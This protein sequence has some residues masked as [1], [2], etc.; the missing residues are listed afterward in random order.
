MD[1]HQITPKNAILNTFSTVLVLYIATLSFQISV[2]YAICASS[3]WFTFF[4]LSHYQILDS[5]YEILDHNTETISHCTSSKVCCCKKCQND[6]LI[7]LTYRFI[8]DAPRKQIPSI[9]AGDL[10]ILDHISEFSDAVIPFDRTQR[11][12]FSVEHAYSFSDLFREVSGTYFKQTKDPSDFWLIVYGDGIP[13]LSR[14]QLTEAWL[15]QYR[16]KRLQRLL[17]SNVDF[18]KLSHQLWKPNGIMCKRAWR[19]IDSLVN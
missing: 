11:A 5:D 13:V 15:H 1:T 10:F 6:I 8:K 4:T 16:I 12:V 2:S 14:D 7:D 9:S 19:M 3:Y 18:E 17:L